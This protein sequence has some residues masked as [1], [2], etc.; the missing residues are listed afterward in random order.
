M[1]LALYVIYCSK[2]TQNFQAF[3]TKLEN[4]SAVNSGIH[5]TFMREDEVML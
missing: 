1:V 4:K 5:A 2:Q 3:A